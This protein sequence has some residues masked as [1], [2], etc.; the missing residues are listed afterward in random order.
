MEFINHYLNVL[1]AKIKLKYKQL[2]LLNQVKFIEYDS[3]IAKDTV[4]GAGVLGQEYGKNR[5]GQDKL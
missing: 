3:Y 5:M 1:K 2:F 4:V